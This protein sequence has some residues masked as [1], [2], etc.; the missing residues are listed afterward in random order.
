MTY[1]VVRGAANAGKP[2]RQLK[3]E[4]GRDRC[5]TRTTLLFQPRCK[6]RRGTGECNGSLAIEIPTFYVA[7]VRPLWDRGAWSGTGLIAKCQQCGGLNEIQLAE[8]PAAA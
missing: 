2:N 4:H 8:R 3:L 5:R 7:L 1:R 6:Q